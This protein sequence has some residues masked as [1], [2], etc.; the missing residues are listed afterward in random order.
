MTAPVSRVALPV[1][2]HQRNGDRFM[3]SL[4]EPGTYAVD[5]EPYG[6]PWRRWS[7][8]GA[9]AA[10]ARGVYAPVDGLYF[11]AP[12]AILV[13]PGDTRGTV[14]IPER[15]DGCCGSAGG[16][17]PNLACE[18]CGAEVAT[19]IDDCYRWQAVWF[20]AAAVRCLP[21]D[22]P[23]DLDAGDWEWPGLPPVEPSGYWSLRWQA[24]VGIALAHVLAASAGAPVA[25]PGGL[26]AATF[27]RT[28]DTLLPSGPPARTLALAGPGL[29]DP[30]PAPDIALV[31]RHPR[32]GA[33]WQPPSGAA[34]PLD[35][36]V[37]T[38]LA[39]PD[40]RAR[41]PATGGLPTGVQRDDPL[42]LRPPS[43][44]RPDRE[45]FL[46]TLARLPEVRQPWLRALYD[47][48]GGRLS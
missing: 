13:A 45:L 15:C 21:V 8:V 18:R 38:Y 44:F 4:M 25:V 31:P 2:A 9:D 5:P 17:G 14:V 24:A 33:A 11:G 43:L 40:D 22:G 47:K 36:E 42:P 12:G 48:A 35:A 3:P 37:W 41:V 7:D 34:V 30:D 23:A 10:A 27:G 46:R 6:P 20:E 19:R 39:F 29:P 26:L 16:L 1:H 32:T 28:L